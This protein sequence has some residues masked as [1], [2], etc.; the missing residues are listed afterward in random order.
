MPT[1]FETAEDFRHWLKGHAAQQTALVVGFCKVCSGRAS[2]RWPEAVDEALCVGWIDG[3]RKRIDDETYQIR[4]TPRKAGSH[5]SG[6]NIERVRV[7]GEAGRMQ[8][9]GLAA[10]ALRSEARSRNAS[11]EQ[12]AMPVLDAAASA[13]FRR[14][15]AA[16]QY[17]E[18]QA[19]SYRKKVLWRI[20]SAKQEATRKRR[21]LA[22]IE[23]SAQGR[24]L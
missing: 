22:L 16:W 9:S 11:Y 8:A 13:Q 20:V 21:L 3:V 1:F 15:P 18:R 17:F 23:A 10:F 5:W 7:L 12:P 4:F 6:V 24:R 14:Q 19:A 2:M